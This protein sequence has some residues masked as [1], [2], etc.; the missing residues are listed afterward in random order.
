M[1]ART[2]PRDFPEQALLLRV[3]EGL[4]EQ[5][6]RDAGVDDVL[7]STL[8]EVLTRTT[9]A[10]APRSRAERPVAAL[11]AR[12]GVA[13]PRR[14]PRACAPPDGEEPARITR[15]FREHTR[16]LLVAAA[17]ERLPVPGMLAARLRVWLAD[18]PA[19]PPGFGEL[20]RWA[21]QLDQLVSILAREDAA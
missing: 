15:V 5:R 3:R 2:L 11:C 20:R 14:T 9:P 8:D 19:A 10:S 17:A 13:P 12:L 6:L 7:L 4:R 1:S 18:D 21:V 16:A